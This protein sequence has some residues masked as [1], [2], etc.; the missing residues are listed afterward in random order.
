MIS[1]TRRPLKDLTH[2][3]PNGATRISFSR[4]YS[5]DKVPCKI[6]TTM[7]YDKFPVDPSDYRTEEHNCPE[8]MV[9]TGIV[10]DED[11]ETTTLICSP[12]YHT[13]QLDNHD[14]QQ[15]NVPYVPN[16]KA[17]WN[18]YFPYEANAKCPVGYILTGVDYSFDQP[19]INI[20]CCRRKDIDQIIS[21]RDEWTRGA[22]LVAVIL[23]LLCLFFFLF[24]KKRQT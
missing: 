11:R 12:V 2:T 23:F 8:D 5:S 1:S 13:D 9:A 7:P 6:K 21:S 10:L 18:F 16:P 17:D 15:I 20:R 4:I 22:I 19:H 3:F 24:V 14:C